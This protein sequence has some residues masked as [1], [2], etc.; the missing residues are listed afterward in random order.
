M[1]P[2]ENSTA[3]VAQH[4]NQTTYTMLKVSIPSLITIYIGHKS[5]MANNW[6]PVSRNIAKHSSMNIRRRAG[7]ITEID[8]IASS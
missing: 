5:A 2:G 6:N 4:P 3:F 7:K 1:T 8:S